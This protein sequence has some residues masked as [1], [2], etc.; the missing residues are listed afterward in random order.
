MTK[1]AN[2]FGNPAQS[3]V[4]V[5]SNEQALFYNKNL[6]FKLTSW[7]FM[8]RGTLH[9]SEA[10]LNFFFLNT[11]RASVSR[12]RRQCKVKWLELENDGF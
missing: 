4:E 10:Y 2:L 6:D 9:T 1:Q 8:R 3:P 11:W 7:T 5:T 12:H